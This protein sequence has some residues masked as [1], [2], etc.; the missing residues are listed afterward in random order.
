MYFLGIDPGKSGGM[1]FLSSKMGTIKLAKFGSRTEEQID[2]L[3]KGLFPKV[4]H[5]AI[6]KVHAM[7]GQGV[8]SMFTFGQSY[9]F[10]RGLLVANGIGFTDVTPQ[11]WQ[12]DLN[13]RTGGDKN[14][15]KRKAQEL[16]PMIADNITHATADAL[17]I[18][19]WN[20]ANYYASRKL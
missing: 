13:C 1:A 3:I 12:K 10:L 4:V 7:P 19:T 18:A 16:Y 11:R 5:A 6:E 20:E 8:V 17:L 9:G 14:V 15:S 2:Q